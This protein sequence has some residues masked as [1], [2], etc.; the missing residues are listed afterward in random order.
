ML[1]HESLMHSGWHD[2]EYIHRD[3]YLSNPK[4]VCHI[5]LFRHRLLKGYCR[6]YCTGILVIT[7]F[8][9]ARQNNIYYYHDVIKIPNNAIC[10][11]F[12]F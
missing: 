8:E 5:D 10:N 2:Y 3:E 12:Y 4:V 9:V 6:S 1:V 11:I 7:G